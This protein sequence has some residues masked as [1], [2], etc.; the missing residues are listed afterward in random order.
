[1]GERIARATLFA[2][3]VCG[4]FKRFR[5]FVAHIHIPISLSK[6]IIPHLQSRSVIRGGEGPQQ[7]RLSSSEPSEVK[8]CFHFRASADDMRYSDYLVFKVRS[9]RR[10]S[11]RARIV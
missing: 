9:M 4:S 8:T 5:N 2:L 1:M 10:F 3:E 6:L 7:V 11:S